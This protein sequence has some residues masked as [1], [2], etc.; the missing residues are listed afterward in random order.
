MDVEMGNAL[1]R[2]VPAVG[3]HAVAIFGNPGEPGRLCGGEEELSKDVTV[4]PRCGGE[5]GDVAARDHKNV[6]WGAGREIVE[7]NHFLV[8][9]KDA[10]RRF[11]RRYATEDASFHA[12]KN[13]KALNPKAACPQALRCRLSLRCT[14]RG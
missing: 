4:A 1:P 11:T 8:G 2:L 6:D 7:G 12:G 9:E 5:R 14:C 10:R 3:D 13:S